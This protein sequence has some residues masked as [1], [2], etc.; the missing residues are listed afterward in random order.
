VALLRGQKGTPARQPKGHAQ[1]ALL[2]ANG[3]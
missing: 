2:S 3:T 1:P